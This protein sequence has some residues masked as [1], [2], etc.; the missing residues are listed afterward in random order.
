M[1]GTAW[2]LVLLAPFGMHVEEEPIPN[3]FASNPKQIPSLLSSGVTPAIEQLAKPVAK[4]RVV[5]DQNHTDLRRIRPL[6]GESW[7]DGGSDL[8]IGLQKP[9][10][11]RPTGRTRGS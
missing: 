5:I 11:G 8:E 4:H 10:P 6:L 2:R 7:R 9:N 1:R 3:F